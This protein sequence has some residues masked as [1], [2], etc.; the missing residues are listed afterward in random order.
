MI[1]AQPSQTNSNYGDGLAV[2][3]ELV[4]TPAVFGLFGAIAL[5]LRRLGRDATQIVIL[6]IINAVLGFMIPNIAWEAHLG[7]LVTGLALAAAYVYAPKKRR[8]AVGVL[9]TVGV[10]VI[11]IALAV[12]KYS[13][14]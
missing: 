1:H 14:V 8:T 9:A 13:L 5:V 4:A 6:V 11:I 3:F 12:L 7:G 10:A 2:A